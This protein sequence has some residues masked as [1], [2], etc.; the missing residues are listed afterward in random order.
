MKGKKDQQ[1]SIKIKKKEIKWK[2]RTATCSLQDDMMPI[3]QFLF[4][5]M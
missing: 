3:H 5:L 4:S 1:N 2:R